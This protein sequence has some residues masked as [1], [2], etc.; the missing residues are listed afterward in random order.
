MENTTT[1][2]LQ[3]EHFNFGH[4]ALVIGVAVSLLGISW[5]KNPQL[6]SIKSVPAANQITVAYY[7]YT[8]SPEDTAPQ[9]AGASTMPSGPS[10]LNEDGSMSPAL[11]LGRVLG[12]S[13]ENITANIES[14][15]INTI[16]DSPEAITAYATRAQETEANLVNSSTFEQAL[17]S[18]NP[19]QINEQVAKFEAFISGLKTMPVPVS[20]A[21]L[22]KLKILQYN[23]AIS[24]LKNFS[25]VE[26]DPQQVS[27]NLG[28]FSQTQQM[29]INELDSLNQKFNFSPAGVSAQP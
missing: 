6:F 3:K 21:K 24:I 7:P 23:A 15:Q 12:V 2:N 26:E 18:N 29:L 5:M 11:D 28:V 14:L 8:P 17:I 16:A 13:T 19:R 22:Q 10:I 9:V 27:T 1:E 25:H 4:L 20:F